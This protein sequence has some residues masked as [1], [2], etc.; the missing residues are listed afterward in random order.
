MSGFASSSTEEARNFLKSC[1]TIG[2]STPYANISVTPDLTPCQR[3]CRSGTLNSDN[4]N[5]TTVD[6]VPCDIPS[7]EIPDHAMEQ[8]F[9]RA[10][11]DVIQALCN[12]TDADIEM[13]DIDESTR[14]NV[15]IHLFHTDAKVKTKKRSK[16]IPP[17]FQPS[18][19]RSVTPQ[20]D[21]PHSVKHQSNVAIQVG[22]FS[23][24]Y[25]KGVDKAYPL[26]EVAPLG[27]TLTAFA[28]FRWFELELVVQANAVNTISGLFCSCWMN[29]HQNCYSILF[30]SIN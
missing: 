29:L 15:E 19:Y 5:R 26:F 13:V 14:N 20:S 2:S 4:S 22:K 17:V 24:R 11:A 1:K 23:R 27:L 30:L 9:S 6:D 18:P 25:D 28:R 10:M 7:S 21:N 3:R 8:T 16:L 12:D